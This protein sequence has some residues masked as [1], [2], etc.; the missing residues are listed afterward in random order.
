MYTHALGQ[1]TARVE[2]GGVR[3]SFYLTT[4][5]FMSRRSKRNSLVI[6][7]H[8]KRVS[9]FTWGRH[10][11]EHF[12]SLVPA[13]TDTLFEGP[14]EPI[15]NRKFE[16]L[17][18]KVKVEGTYAYWVSCPLGRLPT[19]PVPVRVRDR[20]IWWPH[21]E[22]ESRLAALAH[23]QEAFL[24]MRTG[25]WACRGSIW[26]GTVIPTHNLRTRT[27]L[28]VPYWR[29][30]RGGTITAS[31]PCFKLAPRSKPDKPDT[32]DGLQPRVI[33][34]LEIHDTNVTDD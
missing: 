6:R 16:Y 30:T 21:R 29:L 19:G 15:N 7:I 34:L 5:V 26:N 32:R 8:R 3:L 13:A 10:Y 17:D 4:P 1:L 31:C 9:R 2:S 22:I 33:R 25:S 28:R 20:R 27:I 14:I 11:A 23:P 24:S 12:D 18:P